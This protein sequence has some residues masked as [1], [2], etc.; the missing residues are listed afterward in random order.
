MRRELGLRKVARGLRKGAVLRSSKFIGA[1]QF[2]GAFAG[3]FLQARVR[4]QM[5]FAFAARLQRGRG[6]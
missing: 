3:R 6:P 2:G 5:S 1:V 4:G